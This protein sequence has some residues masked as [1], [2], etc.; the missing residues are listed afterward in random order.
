ME[1]LEKPT[2]MEANILLLLVG[3]LLLFIG[4]RVQQREVYSGLLIT[5]YL[6]ILLPNLIFLKFKGYSL[7]KVLKLNKFTFEQAVYTFFIMIFAY[8]VAVFLN[9]IMISILSKFTSLLPT[10]V[11]LP[12][13]LTE[14][15]V[16]LFIMALAPGICEE[17]MFRGTMLNSYS[18]LGNKKSIIISAFLFGVFHFNIFNFIGP[19]FLGIVL[20]V[21]LLKTNSIFTSMIGHTINNSIAL[22]I[23][24]FVTRFGDQI[25]DMAK[26][27]IDIE[28][29]AQLLA[30]MI[31]LL[32]IGI[33]SLFMLIFLLKRIPV[34]DSSL[35]IDEYEEI[36]IDSKKLSIIE[37]IPAL[38]VIG[39][40][41][42]L[43]IKYVFI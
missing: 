36:T 1:R 31:V 9:V 4:Q 5:E 34:N 6:I 32:I 20:G 24:F 21:L 7:K 29:N 3:I 12:S 26:Q 25:D 43:S 13:N 39:I 22:T 41:L 16:G 35:D 19:A 27:P 18:R 30:G 42:Y 28:P 15:G 33:G 14:F 10:G 40:F 17:V 8:P 11:P 38:I 23:G 2:I 37:F